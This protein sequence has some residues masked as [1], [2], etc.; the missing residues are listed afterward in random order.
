M[1]YQTLL[2]ITIPAAMVHVAEEYK[3]GWVEWANNFISGV[4]VKQFM[5]INCFF[6]LLCILAAILNKSLMLFSSSIFSLLLINALAHIAP[7]IK[8]KKY[9]PGLFSSILLF[10]PIGIL[11]Y[12][13]ILS[14]NSM[15]LSE[16][17]ISII[18][19]LS[20]MSVPFIYQAIR[21]IY[22]KD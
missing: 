4:T 22:K 21:I 20:W 6:M 19:G 17:V 5:V 3:F 16:L 9:S 11:G 18:I 10:I 8:Q 12:V 2:I 7:T 1:E 14:D 15:S 13:S